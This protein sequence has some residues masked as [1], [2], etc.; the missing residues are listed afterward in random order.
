MVGDVKKT[1]VMPRPVRKLVVGI[2]IPLTLYETILPAQRE[3]DCHV[4]SLLAMTEY[5]KIA[6]RFVRLHK[7]QHNGTAQGPSPTKEIPYHTK[8]PHHPHPQV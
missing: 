3:T 4:A 1:S 7:V 2:R 8:H 6:R 5:F